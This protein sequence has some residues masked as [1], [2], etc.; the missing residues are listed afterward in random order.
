MQP[1]PPA[2]SR[3]GQVLGDARE[4]K[5]KWKG[6]SGTHRTCLFAAECHNWVRHWESQDVPGLPARAL[7]DHEL[8][9]NEFGLCPFSFKL[10]PPPP[11]VKG[12][13]EMGS[14]SPALPHLASPAPMAPP[15]TVLMVRMHNPRSTLWTNVYIYKRALTKW[16]THYWLDRSSLARCS[17]CSH[18]FPWPKLKLQD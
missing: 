9:G 11:T 2:R 3:Q 17:I 15:A 1:D 16:Q 8:T 18:L 13:P 4:V 6:T 12:A 10:P 5:Q 7:H 14:Q